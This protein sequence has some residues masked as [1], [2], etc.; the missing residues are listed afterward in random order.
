MSGGLLAARLEDEIERRFRNP[1]HA[2]QAPRPDYLAKARLAGQRPEAG[3]S[4]GK[5]DGEAV[6]H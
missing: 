1:A 5:R 6:E 4:L 2:R 3:P